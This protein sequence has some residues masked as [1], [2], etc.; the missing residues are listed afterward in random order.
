MQTNRT[1]CR[2]DGVRHAELVSASNTETLKQVQGDPSH[3]TFPCCRAA[4]SLIFTKTRV[5][6]QKNTQ[7]PKNN[8]RRDFEFV[9]FLTAKV[10]FL[11]ANDHFLKV[12]VHSLT[13]KHHFLIAKEHSL[14]DNVYSLT[15][16]VRFLT[17]NV[18]SLTSN[19]RSLIAKQ[20]SL[21]ENGALPKSK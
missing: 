13:A 16:K 9:R 2:I 5:F 4:N 6:P 8:L 12:K 18:D 11:T 10:H 7:N 20:H 15:V 14:T 17:Y 19:V 1:S 21:R 3:V